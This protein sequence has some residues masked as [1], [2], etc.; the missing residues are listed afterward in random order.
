MFI[1]INR[2][3]GTMNAKE[4]KHTVLSLSD[5]LFPMVARLLGDE[6]NAQD[7]VQ[8]IMIKLWDKRK[9]VGKHPNI[10][11][12]VFLTARNYCM[13][14]L[15]KKNPVFSDPE[16]LVNLYEKGNTGLEQMESREVYMLIISIMEKLPRQQRDIMMMRDLDGLEFTEIAEITHL[17]VEH[18]RVLLSRARKQVK[19]ELKKVYCH[20]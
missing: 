19:V 5:R 8:E 14:L 10:P 11:G 13:D 16:L 17:N 7:A 2:Y 9:K 15:K 12:F 1:R 20:G 6:T 18:I 4:F 3:L